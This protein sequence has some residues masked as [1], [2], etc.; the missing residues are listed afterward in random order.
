MVT[1]IIVTTILKDELDIVI[2]T[3]W[4][5]DFLEM[6][7]PFFEP[8]HLII[9][10]NGDPSKTITVLKGFYYELYNKNDINRILGPKASCNSFKDIAC[11]SLGYMVSKKKYIFTIDDDSFVSKDPYGNDINALHYHIMNLLYPSTPFFFNTLYDSYRED[12]DF[13]HGYLS[14]LNMEHPL[15]FLMAFRW[16]FL[17]MIPPLILSSPWSTT[18]SDFG[19]LLLKHIVESWMP[20]EDNFKINGLQ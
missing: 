15:R 9:V 1:P 14:A 5:L 19:M 20:H 4:K 3:I 7:R 11:R 12:V 8:F 2:P 17:T 18:P 10:E 13:V 16:I 6:W